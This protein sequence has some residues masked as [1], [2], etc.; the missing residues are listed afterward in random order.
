MSYGKSNNSASRYREMEVLSATPGQLVVMVYDHLL[1]NLYRAHLAVEKNDVAA[2]GEALGK[3]REALTELF[4]TLDHDKGGAIAQQ[5]ASLY[6]FFLGE[7]AT[8]GVRPDLT[9][10][11]RITAMITDL[12]EAFSTAAAATPLP[13]AS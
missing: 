13:A 1:Q 7:L 2:C 3:G 10:L 11:E 6:T 5:L 12:R 8:L 9:K 4:A